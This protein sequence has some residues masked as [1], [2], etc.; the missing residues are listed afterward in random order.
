ML[1]DEADLLYCR[2]LDKDEAEAPQRIA[3]QM[4]DQVLRLSAKSAPPT[5]SPNRGRALSRFHVFA[6][7]LPI[8][9]PGKE[10]DYTRLKGQPR[11]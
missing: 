5:L 9:P 11:S 8:E 10:L 4:D 6:L 1:V 7:A 2:R 3:T